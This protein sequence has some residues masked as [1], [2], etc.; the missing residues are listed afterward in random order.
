MLLGYLEDARRTHKCTRK[1]WVGA[2]MW[3][4][5][6]SEKYGRYLGHWKVIKKKYLLCST[7]L[8]PICSS[9]KGEYD[10]IPLLTPLIDP[11]W[12]N[13]ELAIALVKFF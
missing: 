8:V 5:Q 2:G 12:I 4:V 7:H 6:D 3:W 9:R 10:G 11:N 1:V 13:S